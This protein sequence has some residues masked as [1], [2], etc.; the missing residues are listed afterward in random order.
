MSSVNNDEKLLQKL[1]SLG[2]MD[3]ILKGAIQKAGEQVRDAAVMLCPVD[4]GAL[5]QS[6]HEK[7]DVKDGVITSTVYTNMEYAPYVEFGTGPKGAENHQGISP[8][9]SP[10]YNSS[11]WAYINQDGDFVYTE[12]YEARPFMYP[13][14]K[15]NKEHLRK[16]IIKTIRTEV[17]RI[18]ND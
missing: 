3:S 14:L 15:D 6:I 12:G 8:E 17:R 9:V 7:T 1:M 4:T 13:A 11:G 18:C 2:N 10:T 16:Q 5:R